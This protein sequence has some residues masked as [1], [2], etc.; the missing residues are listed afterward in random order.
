VGGGGFGPGGDEYHETLPSG[1][2]LTV[3]KYKLTPNGEPLVKATLIDPRT[4]YD[5][6]HAILR[7]VRTGT[8]SAR[9]YALSSLSVRVDQ[10]Y[11]RKGYATA[12]YDA[13]KKATG[14]NK[15]V[16]SRSLK[17]DGKKFRAKYKE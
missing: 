11:R 3:S 4:G 12:M 17:S 14:L 15:I 2:E 16:V 8:G 7:R 9:T 6:G 5:I 13:I 10:Q 1:I